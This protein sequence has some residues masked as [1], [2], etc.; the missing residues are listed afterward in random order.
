[1]KKQKRIYFLPKTKLGKW[2]ICLNIFFLIVTAISLILVKIL[3]IL[4][5]D[6]GHWWDVTVPIA[7]VLAPIAALVTGIIAV[8]K[9]KERS[10]LVYLSILISIFVILFLL[11][12]SLFISD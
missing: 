2:S 8:K 1:M 5:F 11:L 3:G 7:I 12:H 9:N 4:S 6:E 10:V